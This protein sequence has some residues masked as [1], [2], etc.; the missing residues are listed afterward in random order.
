MNNKKAPILMVSIVGTLVLVLIAINMT[1]YLRNPGGGI[2]EI[3]APNRE[4]L[5]KVSERP[6]AEVLPEGVLLQ[7]MEQSFNSGSEQPVAAVVNPETP[8]IQLPST[9]VTKQPFVT[10][11]TS[12]HWYD[13]ESYQ[14]VNANQGT[15]KRTDP[16]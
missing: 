14:K 1:E 3:A 8:S 9:K 7:K 11:T 15:G 10:N 6:S 2:Q 5:K 16:K 12:A 13:D 4:A